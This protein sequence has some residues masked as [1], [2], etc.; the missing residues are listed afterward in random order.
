MRVKRVFNSDNKS[1]TLTVRGPMV[2]EGNRAEQSDL[3]TIDITFM[4]SKYSLE[5]SKNNSNNFDKREHALIGTTTNSLHWDFMLIPAFA[6]SKLYYVTSFLL[7]FGINV[8][9]ENSQKGKTSVLFKL[10][11]QRLDPKT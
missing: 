8:M 2:M 11:L 5:I 6:E 10:E 1:T 4:L 9:L 7:D 3:K